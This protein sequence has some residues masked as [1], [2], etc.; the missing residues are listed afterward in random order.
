MEFGVPEHAPAKLNNPR[1]GATSV[2]VAKRCEPAAF[3][4]HPGLLS[5]GFRVAGLGFAVYASWFICR[6]AEAE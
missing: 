4:I 2:E 3:V 5:L 6:R 1:H